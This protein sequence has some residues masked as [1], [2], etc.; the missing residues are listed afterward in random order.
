MTAD[1]DVSFSVWA[2]L[3]NSSGVGT[4]A[5]LKIHGVTGSPFANRRKL[6]VIAG[7]H[8]LTGGRYL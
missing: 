5:R 7:I 1:T 8:L 6:Y 3:E 4:E 2:R